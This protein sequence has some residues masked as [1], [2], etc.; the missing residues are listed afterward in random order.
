MWRDD[1]DQ[2]IDAASGIV[3][4]TQLFTPWEKF[5]C[6]LLLQ[7]YTRT[8]IDEELGLEPRET[9]DIVYRMRKKVKRKGIQL[10][11]LIEEK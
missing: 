9:N 10:K 2:A 11:D 5:I 3:T 6:L 1:I 4:V 7:G 8:E